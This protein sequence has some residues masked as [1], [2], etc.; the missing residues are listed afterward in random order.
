M[1]RHEPP[2]S[3]RLVRCRVLVLFTASCFDI[4]AAP[5]AMPRRQFI[6]HKVETD[7]SISRENAATPKALPR[8]QQM[9]RQPK[10]SCRI[11]ERRRGSESKAAAT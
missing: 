11:P 2:L 3:R 9:S 7:R 5:L 8:L 6:C 1:P 4:A 10:R